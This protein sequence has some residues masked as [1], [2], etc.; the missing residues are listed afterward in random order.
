MAGSTCVLVNKNVPTRYISETGSNT[1]TTTNVTG[2]VV[3]ANVPA[4]GQWILEASTT[5]GAYN[6][7]NVS[8]GD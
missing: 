5:S 7:K 8:T 3:V 6:F 2:G 4:T 1:V